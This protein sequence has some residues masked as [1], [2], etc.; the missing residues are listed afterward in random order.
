MLKQFCHKYYLC[1][2]KVE[3]NAAMEAIWA[4]WFSLGVVLGG[5][6]KELNNWLNF[7]HFRFHHWGSFVSEVLSYFFIE[8]VF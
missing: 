1:K 2:T 7:W 4:W 5:S 6:L 8:F 3:A